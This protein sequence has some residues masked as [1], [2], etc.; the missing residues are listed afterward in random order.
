MPQRRAIGDFIR[1]LFRFEDEAAALVEVD[2]AF[3][4]GA[5][6]MVGDYVALE[7]V[8]VVMNFRTGGVGPVDAEEIAEFREEGLAVGAFACAGG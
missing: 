2:A 3:G 1:A 5:I 6:A 8:G 4:D 7:Y